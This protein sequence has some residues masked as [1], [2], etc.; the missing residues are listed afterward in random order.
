MAIKK[1]YIDPNNSKHIMLYNLPCSFPEF[2]EERVDG[3]N[4]YPRGI[5]VLMQKEKHALELELLN[6]VIAEVASENPKVAQVIKHDKSRICVRPGNRDEYLELFPEGCMMLK[7]NT[8]KTPFVLDKDGSAIT[9]P[10]VPNYPFNSGCLVNVK[11]ELWPQDNRKGGKRVNAK[12][13]AVQYAGEGEICFD[14]SF[15]S[16]E[17]ALSGFGAVD[18]DGF[19]SDPLG[20]GDEE[21]ENFL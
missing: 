1:S 7:A 17:T 15:V 3:E 5:T 2:W 18:G 20:G 14:G 11:V 13:L 8:P 12:L 16:A 4:T 21:E 19:G 10:N 6:K 9:G